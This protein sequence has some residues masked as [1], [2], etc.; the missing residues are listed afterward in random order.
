[1]RTGMA[2]EREFAYLIT[3]ALLHL[4]GFM[5]TTTQSDYT[6]HAATLRRRSW[7]QLG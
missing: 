3:H 7:R 4:A 5:H 6:A 1:M 2:P